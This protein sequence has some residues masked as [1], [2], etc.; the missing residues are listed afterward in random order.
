MK[1]RQSYQKNSILVFLIFLQLVT[2]FFW[3]MQKTGY[4]M[5]EIL[6]YGLSNSEYT[7]FLYREDEFGEKWYYSQ[8]IADYLS[9][10][11]Y[12]RFEY[13]SVIYNQEQDVHPPVYYLIFHTISS[14]FEGVFS[15]WI[16]LSINLVCFILIDIVLYLL[17][18]KISSSANVAILSI[19]VW[20]FSVGAINMVTFIRMYALL[21]LWIVLFVYV[22]SLLFNENMIESE[23]VSFK[24][25]FS[26]MAI[27]ILGILTQYYFLVF[28]FF[29]CGGWC[30]YLL[31]KKKWRI[32]LKYSCAEILA[33]F[34]SILI[35]P[36][37][38]RHIFSGYRGDAAFS[39][40][41][42][43]DLWVEHIKTYLSIFSHSIMWGC[44][45]IFGIVAAIVIL[46]WCIQNL[47][48]KFYIHYNHQHKRIE[49][50]GEKQS[51]VRIAWV[52]SDNFVFLI[53]LAIGSCAYLLMIARIAPYQADR[54]IMPLFPIATLY[55]AT[56]IGYACRRLGTKNSFVAAMA[57]CTGLSVFS[58]WIGPLNYLYRDK[59]IRN[60]ISYQYSSLPVIIPY[61]SSHGEVAYYD[62]LLEHPATFFY[63]IDNLDSLK[64]TLYEYNLTDGFLLYTESNNDEEVLEKF[65]EIFPGEFI[66][67]KLFENHGNIYLVNNT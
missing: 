5:D 12:E 11:E 49:L 16:G 59:E 63:S 47:Y 61:Q 27:T 10:N 29:I 20:G 26:L 23:D 33:V 18:K 54:Y 64:E 31:W 25:L 51:S 53:I 34:L 28:S 41:K 24:L 19:I 38:L 56:M 60:Q 9:V 13:K 57:I 55:I 39:A 65:K 4:H 44:L 50:I 1:F 14:F 48:M 15:K 36:G 22:H 30:I 35:F 7:P 17:V 8:E 2:M 42:E 67:E 21:T 46:C 32:L 43:S 37:M 6:S 52:L 58:W 3:G 45:K 66:Y 40:L 62:E